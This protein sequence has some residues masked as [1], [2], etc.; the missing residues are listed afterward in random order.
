MVAKHGMKGWLIE[1]KSVV[2]FAVIGGIIGFSFHL[3][4]HIKYDVE[5]FTIAPH[6][7]LGTLYTVIGA[8]IGIFVWY[9]VNKKSL[10]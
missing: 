5:L 7:I 2:L 10:E 9:L 4:W 3:I 1:H 6:N 8:I